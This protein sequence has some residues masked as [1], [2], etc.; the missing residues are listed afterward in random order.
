VRRL[1]AIGVA[2]GFTAALVEPSLTF[3]LCGPKPARLHYRDVSASSIS[4]RLAAGVPV[5]YSHVNVRHAL[6]FPAVVKGALTVRDSRFLGPVRGADTEFQHLVDFSCST[7]TRPVDLR[8]VRFDGPVLWTRT[9]TAKRAA[10]SFALSSFGEAALFTRAVFHGSTSFAEAGFHGETQFSDTDFGRRANF[11]L[12]G[13]DRPVSFSGTTFAARARFAS[14]DFHAAADFGSAEFDARAIF[15]RAHFSAP[16]E[17]SGASFAVDEEATTSFYSA[18]FDAGATFVAA[19]FSGPLDFSESQSEGDL[20]FEN[21]TFGREATFKNA[22]LLRQTDLRRAT[23]KSLNFDQA[24]LGSVDLR[25]ATIS[26]RLRLPTPGESGDLHA[27]RLDLADT[28]WV[29]IGGS[30]PHDSKRRAL[31]LI[32]A[33]AKADDDL[34]AANEARTRRLSLERDS[35]SFVPRMLDWAFWWGLLGYLVQP[36][37][38]LVAIGAV[39]LIAILVGFLKSSEKGFRRV[40]GAVRGSLGSLFR[41][42]PPD[43]GWRE[44][45][46]VVFKVLTVILIVN[47]GNVWPAFHDLVQGVF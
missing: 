46:Y 25:N 33:T 4:R 27:L 8:D 23:V 38:Q 13:F 10:S 40:W 5:T 44:F 35:R 20:N 36:L 37:H 11:T 18:H 24:F 16:P 6:R 22:L 31:G 12:A 26:G 28:R 34:A 2:L 41:L 14:A 32:E 1:G 45:E 3:A 15:A 30:G 47:I 43:G 17:F 21:S 29:D 9:I 19:D 7:F 42:R 39:L